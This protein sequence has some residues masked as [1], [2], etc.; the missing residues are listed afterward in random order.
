MFSSS[1]VSRQ[2][3]KTT[4]T[5]IRQPLIV[6]VQPKLFQS[7]EKNLKL[8]V[9]RIAIS[10]ML[11]IRNLNVLFDHLR[12]LRDMI[13]FFILVIITKGCYD[14]LLSHLSPG[15]RVSHHNR[16]SLAEVFNTQ[17]NTDS[18]DLVF[19]ELDIAAP[20][21]T[22]EASPLTGWFAFEQPVG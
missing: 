5:W 19:F 11:L 21:K 13:D 4:F 15:Q 9:T 22:V 10:S 17:N 6:I 7:K 3:V 1:R 2:R 8:A 18:A 14:D 20:T 12:I 16:W